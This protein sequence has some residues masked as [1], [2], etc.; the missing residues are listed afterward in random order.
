MLLRTAQVVLLLVV[1][2]VAIDAQQ[3]S[4][5]VHWA[6]KISPV[7][8]LK[9]GE[10]ATATLDAKI[11]EG[12]HVY[13]ISQPPGGPA[14]TVISVPSK[15]AIRLDGKV[16]GPV[17]ESAYDPNFEMQT[18]FYEE[19][20]IFKVPLVVDSTAKAGPV[21]GAID[22]LFQACNDRLCL[23]PTTIQVPLTFRV[24]GVGASTKRPGSGF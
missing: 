17:P 7:H 9:P 10:K 15:Q 24:A 12:W 2:T 11:E 5:I 18:E 14:T 4:D 22:V 3:A 13:S 8:S 6:A 23:P 21:K 20:A 1:S 16:T 19:S